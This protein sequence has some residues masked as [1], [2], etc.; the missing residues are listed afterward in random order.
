MLDHQSALIDLE[1]K[2]SRKSKKGRTIMPYSHSSTNYLSLI[3]L[4]VDNSTNGQAHY[5]ERGHIP[6]CIGISVGERIKILRI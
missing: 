3:V 2:K 4:I 5:V 6:W 1:Q